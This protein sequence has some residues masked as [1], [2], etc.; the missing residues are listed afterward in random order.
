MPITTGMLLGMI[1]QLD[2]RIKILEKQV[3]DPNTPSLKEGEGTGEVRV[4]EDTVSDFG[5][6]HT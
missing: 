2:K 3:R 6:L 5:A 4:R 1:K